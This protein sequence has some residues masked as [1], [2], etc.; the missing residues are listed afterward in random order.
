MKRLVTVAALS[1]L[2]LAGC[3]RNT[4][5]GNDREA[6]RDPPAQAAPIRPAGS[7]L[8]NVSTALIKPETMSDADV[9]AIGG[10]EGRCVFTLTEVSFPAFVYTPGEQGF[11]K[12]N[13]TL[14]PLDPAGADRFESGQLI[15]TTRLLDTRGNAGLRGLEM[16]VV[17]PGAGDELGYR[18]YT[19]C[20]G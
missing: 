19:S 14:I 10:T 1:A 5:I 6:G 17:P 2:A 4:A 11:I 18:G 16:I 3:N 15:V 13:G 20:D 12:L 8:R 7:A 9:A